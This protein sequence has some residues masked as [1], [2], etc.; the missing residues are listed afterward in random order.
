MC[1]RRL[2]RTRAPC[3]AGRLRSVVGSFAR[4]RTTAALLLP[5]FEYECV[6]TSY[7]NQLDRVLAVVLKQLSATNVAVDPSHRAINS[8]THCAT[9]THS[10]QHRATFVQAPYQYT[11][12]HALLK[13]RLRYFANRFTDS[14]YYRGICF[15][16]AGC[17]WSWQCHWCGDHREVSWATDLSQIRDI[18]VIVLAGC[19]FW[20]GLVDCNANWK[21]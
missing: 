20:L 21:F 5:P 8:C 16:A 17:G 2:C 6:T 11:H 12:T 18:N 14:Q 9:L 1:A 15:V 19:Q 13:Y 4:L 3:P 7:T 10:C